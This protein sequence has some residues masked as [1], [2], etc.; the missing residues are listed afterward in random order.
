MS[1]ITDLTLLDYALITTINLIVIKLAGIQI[2][3]VA[4]F[5][6]LWVFALILAAL[7]AIAAVGI[8][9]AWIIVLVKNSRRS[10]NKEAA[11]DA[12]DMF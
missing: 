8:F 3:W 6:P 12:E 1:K 11:E 9:I 7:I 5:S 4:A 2:S 10:T